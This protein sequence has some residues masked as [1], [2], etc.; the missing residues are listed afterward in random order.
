MT[1]GNEEGGRKAMENLLAKDPM[2]NV[3][4]IINEPGSRCLQ[5]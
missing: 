1:F 4:Y 2:I 5:P 3:I